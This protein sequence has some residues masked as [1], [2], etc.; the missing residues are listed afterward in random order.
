M[1]I[2]PIADSPRVALLTSK[3]IACAHVIK[4]EANSN[5]ANAKATSP[6]MPTC[7]DLATHV[8]DLHC[9]R[10]DSGVAT[11]CGGTCAANNGP[12]VTELRRSL[13]ANGSCVTSCQTALRNKLRRNLQAKRRFA[14]CCQTAVCNKIAEE[15]YRKGKC[16]C[17]LP[18][19]GA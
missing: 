13:K 18:H 19:S 1:K 4:L 16:C 14:T 2:A 8:T 17:I 6:T 11:K 3:V 9:I 12:N 7:I 5:V 15:S 10:A